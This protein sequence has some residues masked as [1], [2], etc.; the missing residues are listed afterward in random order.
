M[1]DLILVDV[2]FPAIEL[3]SAQRDS[4]H[5]KDSLYL[6]YC[7][8]GSYLEEV[9]SEWG[10]GDGW[11]GDV[12]MAVSREPW[13]DVFIEFPEFSTLGYGTM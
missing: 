10:E 4:S 8:S 11:V 3:Q 6:Q 7:Q 13:S 2:V 1:W 5:L 9:L 12:V